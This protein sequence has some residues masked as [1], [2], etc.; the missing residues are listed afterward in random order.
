MT[1]EALAWPNPPTLTNAADGSPTQAYNMGVAFTIAVTQQCDGVQWRVPDAVEAP[2]GGNHAIAIW[3]DTAGTRTAIK[4]IDP[5][6]YVGTTQ[7]FLFDTPLTLTAGN[8]IATIYT[9]HYVFRGDNPTGVSTPSGSAVAGEG[10]LRT[11][12]SGAD[13]AGI[14]SSA[15]AATYYVSPLIDVAGGGTETHITTGT[16]STTLHAAAA[17]T[18]TRT[19]TGTAALTLHASALAT[20][21][22]EPEVDGANYDLNDIFDALA[23]TF[24]GVATGVTIE[25]VAQTMEAHSEVVGQVDA[26]AVVLELDDQNYDLN[27]GAGADSFA[28]VAL[29]L[30]TDQDDSAAQRQLRSF[31]SR[32]AGSGLMRLKTALEDNQDLGGIV[33]YAIMTNVRSVGHV[34][35]GGIDYLGAELIIEVVS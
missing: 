23:A 6:P 11:D 9:T 31:I 35:Y 20:G 28:I 32:K 13:A 10:R 19:R 27:M 34:I 7:N 4:H 22:D 5:T 25:G 12:N 21:G 18:T 17:V 29:L 2:P 33:S 8:Y 24:N 3:D 1:A 15:F 30:L 26:P 16:A 14:P